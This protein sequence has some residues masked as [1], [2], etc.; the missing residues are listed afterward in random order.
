MS[1]ICNVP[2]SGITRRHN[3]TLTLNDVLIRHYAMYYISC[4]CIPWCHLV[5][6]PMMS[7]PD[8][9]SCISLFDIASHVAII[10]RRC[11]SWRHY[12]TLHLMTSLPDVAASLDVITWRWVTWHHYLMWR[13]MTSSLDT[14]SHDVITWCGVPWNHHLTLHLMTSLPDTMPCISLFD[15]A[16]RHYFT[17]SLLHDVITLRSPSLTKVALQ[18]LHTWFRMLRWIFMW[19]RI[20]SLCLNIC[21][22]RWHL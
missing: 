20:V 15:V 19:L 1:N 5:L 16:W 8:A 14:A 2:L 7:L 17:T 13:P 22:H 11:V 9:M 6:R 10:W 4:C 18:T 3:L 12:L 21:P